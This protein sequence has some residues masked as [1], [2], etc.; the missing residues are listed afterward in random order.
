MKATLMEMTCPTKLI[1]SDLVNLTNY[2]KNPGDSFICGDFNINLVN[3]DSH[4]PSCNFV[5]IVFYQLYPLINIPIS[6]ISYSYNIY[7]C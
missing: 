7:I 3:L 1:Y 6:I 4:H 5:N 2:L